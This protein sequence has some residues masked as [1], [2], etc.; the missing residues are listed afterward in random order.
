MGSGVQVASTWRRGNE[1]YTTHHVCALVA[2]VVASLG[3]SRGCGGACAVCG[4][5]RDGV[6]IVALL[7]FAQADLNSCKC[8]VASVLQAVEV[9]FETALALFPEN[10]HR[11]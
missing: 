2:T 1:T 4:H 10:A 6:I 3:G 7:C 8:R 9:H 5:L 11:F